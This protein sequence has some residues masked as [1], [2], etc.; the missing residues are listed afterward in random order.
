MVLVESLQGDPR[1]DANAHRF[2]K[3]CIVETSVSELTARLDAL[4]KEREE[5]L[6]SISG[7]DNIWDIDPDIALLAAIHGVPYDEAELHVQA[8]NIDDLYTQ[9]NEWTGHP[10]DGRYND[11]LADLNEQIDA[12]AGGDPETA[13]LIRVGLY[14]GLTA[15]QALAAALIRIEEQQSELPEDELSPFEQAQH[16]LDE[17][18]AILDTAKFDQENGIGTTVPDQIWSTEDL[19]VIIANENGYYTPEQV[20]HAQT[21]LAMVNSSPEAREA[22]GITESGGG[23]AWDDIGHITLDVLGLFPVVGNAADGINATW[24]AAEGDYLNAALSSMALL[25]GIGQAVTLAG[26]SVRA[27]LRGVPFGSLDEALVAVREFLE[28]LG[29]LGRNSDG[30]SVLRQSDELPVV[31]EHPS[32]PTRGDVKYDEFGTAVSVDSAKLFENTNTT[33]NRILDD[34]AVQDEMAEAWKDSVTH[35]GERE[36]G[37]WLIQ[38]ADGSHSVQRWPEGD[39]AQIGVPEDVPE[40]AVGAFHT[41]PNRV[42]TSGP[43]RA[44]IRAVQANPE[45]APHYIVSHDGVWVIDA[46]GNAVLLG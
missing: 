14:E 28:N 19:Q 41:H 37:G 38:N 32:G 36:N 5:L 8:A 39:P 7:M 3:M 45:I 6:T 31:R 35:L 43:S 26:G 23:W 4:I 13:R 29:I 16:S 22:L 15:S 33:G 27:A 9:V 24:Y 42:G 46:S 1:R 34:V 30:A 21:V 25:P 10:G 11:M 18:R 20:T 44:D 17:I 2:L 12:L 40:N